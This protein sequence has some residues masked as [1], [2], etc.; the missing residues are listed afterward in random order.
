MPTIQEQYTDF[1]QRS[2]ESA[3]A[4][5]DAW[6]ESVQNLATR[7]PSVANQAAAH[8]V[9]D[10]TFAFFGKVLDV[11]R[12]AAKQ[13][14]SASATAAEQIAQHTSD[15]ISEAQADITEN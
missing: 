15:V 11:Q 1:A 9:I 7:V 6:T 8:Q 2:Q 4:I 5:V 14:V 10:Q 13:F 12:D 3:M